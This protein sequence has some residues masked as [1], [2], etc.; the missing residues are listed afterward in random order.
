MNRLRVQRWGENT[1]CDHCGGKVTLYIKMI[2]ASMTFFKFLAQGSLA[3]LASII[4][5]IQY[6][7]YCIHALCKKSGKIKMGDK[8][9]LP[10]VAVVAVDT[11]K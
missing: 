5:W 10:H 6:S 3:L 8:T 11:M 2:T 4:S 9:M 1:K 7:S